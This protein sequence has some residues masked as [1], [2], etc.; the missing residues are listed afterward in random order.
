ME[1]SA[2]QRS[3]HTTRPRRPCLL[4]SVRPSRRR[5]TRKTA[6]RP[7]RLCAGLIFSISVPSCCVLPQRRRSALPQHLAPPSGSP[8][9]RT[10]PPG[11]AEFDP[12]LALAATAGRKPHAPPAFAD[13]LANYRHRISAPYSERALVTCHHV[14]VF[15]H[16][17]PLRAGSGV[18]VPPARI[19]HSPMIDFDTLNT[20]PLIPGETICF[21]RSRLLQIAI[22]AFK[23]LVSLY[24]SAAPRTGFDSRQ[25]S[26]S[27]GRGPGWM[28]SAAGRCWQASLAVCASSVAL[29]VPVRVSSLRRK[30]DLQMRIRIQRRTRPQARIRV[31]EKKTVTCRVGVRG[32]ITIPQ[33]FEH[34][35][36]GR[37]IIITEN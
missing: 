12:T 28:D 3:D 4:P 19:R 21:W 1:R 11:R 2:K 30:G 6:H 18:Y 7:A 36:R 14:S 10:D 31:G 27:A 32:W 8:L 35:Y 33:P 23:A 13:L 25:I 29:K 20:L 9:P 22:S 24:S 15:T 34:F 37:M 26:P 17:L 5:R 16:L